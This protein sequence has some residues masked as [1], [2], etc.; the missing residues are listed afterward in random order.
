MASFKC[1]ILFVLIN[2]LEQTYLII[3]TAISNKQRIPRDPTNGQVISSNPNAITNNSDTEVLING[4]ITYMDQNSSVLIMTP[5]E[6]MRKN[7]IHLL[8][9]FFNIISLIY[10]TIK[11]SFVL[12]SMILSQ[13]ENKPLPMNMLHFAALAVEFGFCLLQL[14]SGC[15]SWV[16]MRRLCVFAAAQRVCF[17]RTRNQLQ[18][19]MNLKRLFSMSTPERFHILLGFLMLILC[20]LSNVAVPYFFGVA[21]DAAN[22]NSDLNLMNKDVFIMFTVILLG[23]VAGGFR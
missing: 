13:N 18:K 2:E 5:N 22:A 21:V 12:H 8:I 4:S 10:T 9:M 15:L 7:I 17:D 11:F 20:S 19:P 16:Y 1:L 3:A 6:N 23:A 14:V